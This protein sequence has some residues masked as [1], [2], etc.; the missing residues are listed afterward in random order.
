RG[1][2]GRTGGAGGG[3]A[4]ADGAGEGGSEGGSAGA[5]GSEVGGEGGTFEPDPPPPPVSCD[6]LDLCGTDSPCTTLYVPGGAVRVGRSESGSDAYIAGHEAEQPEHVVRVSPFWLDK[7]EVTVGRFRRFVDAYDDL[8]LKA[9][10]GNHPNRESSGWKDEFF[11][12]LPA[13]RNA[14]KTLMISRDEKCNENFRTW[15][16]AAGANE[17]LPVNCIDWYVSYAFCIWD[18]GRLPSDAEWEFAAAGGDENRLFPW[19][20]D[21]P[22][23]PLAVFR[24]TATGDSTCVPSDIRSVGSTTSD[25]YGRFGHADLAGSMMERTR[26][27]MDSNYY[28][29]E[30]SRGEDIVNL[31]FDSTLVYGAGRGGSFVSNG[32]ELRA[33]SREQVF[34]TSRWDGVGVRCAR[35]LPP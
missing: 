28:N 25:G 16:P 4:G 6:E 35:N 21:D 30:A 9:G 24:C 13:D 7:Y 5:A 17:C 22:D 19:G 34:R 15:T 32:S 8:Q 14:L 1:G 33:A 23:D 26:D 10:M 27:V 31:S 3:Q 11:Q 29:L 20:S 18:G 12:Y 2:G